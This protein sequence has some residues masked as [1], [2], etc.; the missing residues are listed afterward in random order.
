MKLRLVLFSLLILSFVMTSFTYANDTLFFS[1]TKVN[2]EMSGQIEEIQADSIHVYRNGKFLTTLLNTDF[3]LKSELLAS[4]ADDEDNNDDNNDDK[5]DD[6]NSDNDDDNNNLNPNPLGTAFSDKLEVYLSETETININ[7]PDLNY[8]NVK[9]SLYDALGNII[10]NA[11]IDIH[12]GENSYLLKSRNLA[13]GAYFVRLSLGGDE[14]TVPVIYDR[15]TVNTSSNNNPAANTPPSENKINSNDNYTFIGF[16]IPLYETSIEIGDIHS[17]DII[18]FEFN[19]YHMIEFSS[20][21]LFINDL[22]VVKKNYRRFRKTDRSGKDSITESTTYDTTLVNYEI[23]LENAN[24][25]FMCKNYL[26]NNYGFNVLF[27]SPRMDGDKKIT[28]YFDE[29][30]KK[31]SNFNLIDKNKVSQSQGPNGNSNEYE[32]HLQISEMNFTYDDSE[33]VYTAVVQDADKIDYFSDEGNSSN[34]SYLSGVRVTY[35]VLSHEFIPGVSKI[36]L[37]LYP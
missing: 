29:M 37:E 28:M 18:N 19:E 33:N 10:E 4:K 2:P 14:K 15:H 21:K 34:Y 22:K 11:E 31:V 36:R 3:V 9:L 20:G 30:K 32:I 5:D 8:K 23:E 12:S 35:E 6:E 17:V 7:S 25:H 1:A 24:D 26:N 16:K 13:M 27:C